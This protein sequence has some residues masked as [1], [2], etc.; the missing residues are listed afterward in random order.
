MGSFLGTAVLNC[1]EDKMMIW[2]FNDVY[3]P[4]NTFYSYGIETDFST[5]SDFFYYKNMSQS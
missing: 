2:Y 4:L 5:S 3:S 1:Y